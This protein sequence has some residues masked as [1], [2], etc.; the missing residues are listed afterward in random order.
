MSGFKRS[1]SKFSWDSEFLELRD[2]CASP[3][4][5]DSGF[6]DTETHPNFHNRRSKNN[7]KTS[8]RLV[9]SD[10]KPKKP[11]SVEVNFYSEPTERRRCDIRSEKVSKKLFNEV[12]KELEEPNTIAG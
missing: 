12:S 7:I 4:S 2:T 1:P 11:C 5:Q 10:T 8:E 6:S 3:G 9:K